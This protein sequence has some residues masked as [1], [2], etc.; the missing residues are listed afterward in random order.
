[1]KY[2]PSI[3]I[4]SCFCCLIG[5]QSFSSTMLNRLGDNSFVGNSNGYGKAGSQARPF[6][7]IPITLQVPSHLDVYIDEVYY[8][9]DG[10]DKAQIVEPLADT[11]ILKVRTELIKTKK[12][13]TVDYKRPGSGTLNSNTQLSDEQYFKS[14]SNS[15][16]DTTIT[17]SAALLNTVLTGRSTS[18]DGPTTAQ[19][20]LMSNLVRD[21]RVVAYKRFDINDPDFEY[22]VEAFVNQNLNDCDQCGQSPTYDQMTTAAN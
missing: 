6:K 17:D 4:A 2:T 16:I 1:M 18:A 7:G 11:R 5:C 3:L 19:Q 13:F 12:V 9:Q 20:S 10:G 21:T 8:L 15:I 14:I 22:Q